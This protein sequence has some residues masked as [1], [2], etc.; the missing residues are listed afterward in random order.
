MWANYK[1]NV[2]SKTVS[3][4]IHVHHSNCLMFAIRKNYKLL[5]NAKVRVSY[6]RF[7]NP[8]ILPF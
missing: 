3:T 5:M 6:K 1:T 8:Y 2:S 4:T 7:Y